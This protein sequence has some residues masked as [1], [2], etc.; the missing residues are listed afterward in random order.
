MVGADEIGD[1]SL[2]ILYLSQPPVVKAMRWP[3]RSHAVVGTRWWKISALV[4]PVRY[5][6]RDVT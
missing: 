6:P 3:P 4:A 1:L 2:V 5:E